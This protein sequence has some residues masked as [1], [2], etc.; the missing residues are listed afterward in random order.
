VHGTMK[1]GLSSRGL[2]CPNRKYRRLESQVSIGPV[3]KD[4]PLAK[5]YECFLTATTF[6]QQEEYVDEIDDASCVTTVGFLESAVTDKALARL[7][8]VPLTKNCR[9]I[10]AG[11]YNLAKAIQPIV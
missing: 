6:P 3:A 5:D 9:S 2:H 7:V 1:G 11:K 10:R 4:A 8:N